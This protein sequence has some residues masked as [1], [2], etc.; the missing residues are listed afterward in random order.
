MQ[1]FGLGTIFGNIGD[2]SSIGSTTRKPTMPLANHY[3]DSVLSRSPCT[4]ENGG[5]QAVVRSLVGSQRLF[6]SA[7]GPKSTLIPPI[8]RSLPRIPFARRPLAEFLCPS[9]VQRARLQSQPD[10]APNPLSWCVCKLGASLLRCGI[11]VNS[12]TVKYHEQTGV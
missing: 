5:P 9:P 1:Y 2:S 4:A 8:G 10:E 6:P 7:C 11:S 12:S 3:L